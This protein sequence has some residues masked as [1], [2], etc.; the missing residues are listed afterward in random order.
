[1]PQ[2]VVNGFTDR[3]FANAIWAMDKHECVH[4]P[5]CVRS[6]AVAGTLAEACCDLRFRV[7]VNTNTTGILASGPF[8][9][10][11]AATVSYVPIREVR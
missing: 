9:P 2:L 7:P 8:Q 4:F 1:M 5:R 6:V 11:M 3:R 10:A